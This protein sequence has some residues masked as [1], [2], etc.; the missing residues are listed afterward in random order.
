M[1]RTASDALVDAMIAHG[2]PSQI[3]ARF[4]RH[5]DAGANHV[6]VQVFTNP[7]ELMPSPT[8]L[9]GPLGLESGS[10]SKSS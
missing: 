8:E 10:T 9:A 7:D 2:T 5:I 3:A 6:A 1:D 4:R